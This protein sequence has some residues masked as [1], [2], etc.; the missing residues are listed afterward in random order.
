MEIEIRG[1]PARYRLEGDFFY[2]SFTGSGQTHMSIQFADQN[3]DFTAQNIYGFSSIVRTGT[4]LPGRYELR[5][6]TEADLVKDGFN[7]QW[8][9][10]LRIDQ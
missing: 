5:F 6:R 7:N 2:P 10:R 8:N 9:F 4:L 1:A 3:I